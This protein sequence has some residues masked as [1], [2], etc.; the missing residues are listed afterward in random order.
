MIKRSCGDGRFMVTMEDDSMDGFGIRK[1]DLL[2]AENADKETLRSG[3]AVVMVD[4]EDEEDD[5]VMVV[6]QIQ[7]YEGV[8]V[9]YSSELE[10]APIA[11]KDDGKRGYTVIGKVVAIQRWL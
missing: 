6:R 11:I 1:G 10:F 2:I 3:L 5:P 9:I 4:P 8:T 7:R